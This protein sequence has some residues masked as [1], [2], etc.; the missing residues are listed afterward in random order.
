MDTKKQLIC[1]L[2]GAKI[3]Y[4]RTLCGMNQGGLSQTD[5]AKL[6]N[7]H[8]D[9]ISRLERGAYNDSVPL[10]TLID[11]ADALGIDVALLLSISEDEK[12]L[13]QWDEGEDNRT[14]DMVVI[15]S[16]PFAGWRCFSK[17]KNSKEGQTNESNKTNYRGHRSDCIL[18]SCQ[19]LRVLRREPPISGS[20]TANDA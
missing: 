8:P 2:I 15:G 20:Q 10:S 3:R 7:L 11:I 16:S 14:E 9:T 19:F 1:K 4:Y 18:G 13:I 17:I 5:V 12:K 6:A